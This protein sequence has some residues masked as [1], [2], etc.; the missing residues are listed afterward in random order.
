MPGSRPEVGVG[1]P[2]HP[3]AGAE[4]WLVYQKGQVVGGEFSMEWEEA[5]QI[6]KA[7]RPYWN[8]FFPC[9]EMGSH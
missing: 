1:V 9:L 3:K 4:V 7:S 8:L 2:V 6:S 5:G